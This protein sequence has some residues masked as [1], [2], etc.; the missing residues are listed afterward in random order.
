[1]DHPRGS[2]FK[3]DISDK[4]PLLKSP[5]RNSSDLH[6]SHVSPRQKHLIRR[7]LPRV[8]PPLFNKTIDRMNIATCNYKRLDFTLQ[9]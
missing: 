7:Q 4:F 6:D 5:S 9:E 1:M 2:V 3:N 8:V